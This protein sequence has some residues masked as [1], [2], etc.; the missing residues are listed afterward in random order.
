M[1]C[2]GLEVN[3]N[4]SSDE[5]TG[6]EFASLT[7]NSVHFPSE[8]RDNFA[9]E[10][11]TAPV[12]SVHS[13]RRTSPGGEIGEQLYVGIM[14]SNKRTSYLQHFIGQVRL[15]SLDSAPYVQVDSREKGTLGYILKTR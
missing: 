14:P 10:A 11:G 9:P 5:Q 6:D 12:A 4:F 7:N 3:D 13:H 8:K 2:R 15:I 1:S